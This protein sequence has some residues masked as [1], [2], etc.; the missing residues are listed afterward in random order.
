MRDCLRTRSQDY[1][2][3]SAHIGTCG[4]LSLAAAICSSSN[5]MSLLQ[6]MDLASTKWGSHCSE[7]A[8]N[9]LCDVPGAVTLWP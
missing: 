4:C 9:A 3:Y 6:V 8:G 5:M 7:Q 2:K 1:G